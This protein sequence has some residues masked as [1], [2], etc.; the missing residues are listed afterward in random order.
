MCYMAFKLTS[1]PVKT[2][3]NRN[4]SFIIDNDA[5]IL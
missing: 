2:K 1:V 4:K 5:E 3:K